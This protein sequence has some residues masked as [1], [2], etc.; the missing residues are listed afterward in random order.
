LFPAPAAVLKAPCW[1]VLSIQ[2]RRDHPTPISIDPEVHLIAC[3]HHP[4]RLMEGLATGF[5]LL[6]VENRV[7]VIEDAVDAE[8]TK[9]Q[10][11]GEEDEEEEREAAEE[12][13]YG[14]VVI[15]GHSTV[16]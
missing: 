13:R 4:L 8:G 16:R 5:G 14:G 7:E 6:R 12:D 9:A 1:L 2:K 11:G 15:G 10:V 3:S